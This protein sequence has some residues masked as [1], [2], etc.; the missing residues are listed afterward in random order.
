M[1]RPTIFQTIGTLRALFFAVF[2]VREAFPSVFQNAFST[3]PLF[4]CRQL[5]F[6]AEHFCFYCSTLRRRWQSLN[7]TIM[8]LFTFKYRKTLQ[9]VSSAL[10]KG[11]LGSIYSAYLAI[12]SILAAGSERLRLLLFCLQ[13]VNKSNAVTQ[14]SYFAYCFA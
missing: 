5:P 9:G 1:Q 11:S 8:V 14:R 12:S 6:R 3:Q 10:H 13:A 7:Y 2:S 4:P